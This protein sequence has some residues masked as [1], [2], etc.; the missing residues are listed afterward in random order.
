[1]ELKYNADTKAFV[2]NNSGA[3]SDEQIESVV[4]DYLEENP[5]E[6][7]DVDLTEYVKKT[8]Y[9]TTKTKG[10][11]NI[12]DGGGISVNNGAIYTQLASNTEINAKS[13]SFKIISPK[14]LD[15]AVKTA[16][17]DNSITLTDEERAA[18]HTWLGLGAIDSALDELHAYAQALIS[19][20][21][22]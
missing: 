6:T 7:S 13:N 15:Y 2:E 19:G 4:K 20:G 17:C 22:S 12:V 10:I 18:A 5:P 9:A 3:I 11:V 16:I 21:G 14:N 1:M 8:D